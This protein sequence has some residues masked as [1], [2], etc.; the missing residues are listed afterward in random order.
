MI[1]QEKE[2]ELSEN[3]NAGPDTRKGTGNIP[4]EKVIGVTNRGLCERDFLTQVERAASLGL[5]ALILRE[6]DLP[7]EEYKNLAV[8]VMEICENY[9]VRCILHKYVNVAQ[10]IGCRF[11]HFPL[12]DLLNLRKEEAEKQ[13]QNRS[14]NGKKTSV[15]DDFVM[16]GA[17]VHS[18]EDARLAV[19]A[20]CT[21]ITVGHIFQTD[22]KKDLTPR[23]IDFL[24]NI[25][26][27]VSVPV[28]GIGGIHP[29][30]MRTVLSAGASGIC[31]MSEIMHV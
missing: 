13:S 23:G 4:W 19:E 1:I 12:A 3:L 31:M 11:I 24:Q 22:C 10:Q 15:T 5:H 20:G 30:N 8:S 6:K 21:Y 9:G 25:C 18:A 7:E 29:D 27:T 16:I 26:K 28:F 2:R 14:A 17:S